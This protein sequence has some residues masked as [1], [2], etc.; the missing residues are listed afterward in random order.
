MAIVDQEGTKY[1]ST[2]N[3]CLKRG[4]VK[5]FNT[6]AELAIANQVD[7]PELAETV[8]KYNS[9]VQKG[10]DE[11]FG[12]PLKGDL[13]PLDNPPYYAIRLVPKVHHCM[14]GVQINTQA[15]VLHMETQRP[16]GRLYAAG[17][18]T[19]GIHGGSR[20]GSN[21]TIDCL[22]FGRIAGRNAAKESS[23]G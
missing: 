1:A 2:L 3:Q 19:G 6:I 20:L 22:V 5:K 11:E 12:K 9:F 4:V 15:Q 18:I 21:A 13:L 23:R 10:R 7:I 14:G 16:I 8:R 17:E